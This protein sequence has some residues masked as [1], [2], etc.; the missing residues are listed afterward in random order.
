MES[1]G[2]FQA[3]RTGETGNSCV[4]DPFGGQ[5]SGILSCSRFLPTLLQLKVWFHD[6]I[7]DPIR[8]IPNCKIII[9]HTPVSCFVHTETEAYSRTDEQSA[10]MCSKCVNAA[11]CFLSSTIRSTS[12][13]TAAADMIFQ[14]GVLPVCA[15]KICRN[16]MYKKEER[17]SSFCFEKIKSF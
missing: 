4:A 1:S 7:K 6:R 8:S 16:F 3:K 2:I 15:W 10:P 17:C 5:R 14:T 9:G 12:T 13:L 11:N